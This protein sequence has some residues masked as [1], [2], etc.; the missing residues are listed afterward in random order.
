MAATCMEGEDR[1]KEATNE[2]SM[3]NCRRRKFPLPMKSEENTH[4]TR[5]RALMK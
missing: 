4:S 2:A 1:E 3:Q 5:A